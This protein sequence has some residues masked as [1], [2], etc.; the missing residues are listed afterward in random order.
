MG[1]IEAAARRLEQAVDRLEAACARLGQGADRERLAAELASAK[2]DYAALAEA[3][4]T[5]ATRLD[6]TISRLNGVIEE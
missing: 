5:V 3:T 2:A 1:K 4:G 6:A